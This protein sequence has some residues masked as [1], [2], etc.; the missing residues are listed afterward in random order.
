MQDG[1]AGRRG[2][3]GEEIGGCRA[4]AEEAENLF[5]GGGFSRAR[6]QHSRAY[7]AA[8][9]RIGVEGAGPVR[10]DKMPFHCEGKE[11]IEWD[12]EEELQICREVRHMK[13]LMTMMRTP[14]SISLPTESPLSG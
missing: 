8:N 13:F 11:N 5:R 6:A 1:H 7:Q 14:A 12:V 2:H 10:G 4:G 3:T 9:G